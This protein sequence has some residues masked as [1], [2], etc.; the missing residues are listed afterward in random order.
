MGACCLKGEAKC[1]KQEEKAERSVEGRIS[2]RARHPNAGAHAFPNKIKA[3]EI[4]PNAY[5]ERSSA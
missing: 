3:S 1:R 2:S 5:Q 4:H